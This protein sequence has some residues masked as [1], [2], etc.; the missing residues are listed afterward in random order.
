MFDHPKTLEEAARTRYNSWAGNPNGNTYRPGRC[1][2][3]VQEPGRGIFFYQ[4][5]RKPGHGPDSL[6]CKQHAKRVEKE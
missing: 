4:C 1:A 3:E 5:L 2:Y 6:Y